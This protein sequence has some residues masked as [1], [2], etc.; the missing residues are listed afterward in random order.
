MEKS[1]LAEQVEAGKKPRNSK[2]KHDFNRRSSLL[3]VC[4]LISGCTNQ[5]KMED[6]SA[7]IYGLEFNVSW[8]IYFH[9]F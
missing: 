8:E 3:C 7:V 6:D 9:L 2:P 1:Q 5:F 4:K